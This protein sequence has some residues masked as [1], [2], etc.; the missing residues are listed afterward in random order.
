MSPGRPGG[1]RRGGRPDGAGGRRG[2]PRGQGGSGAGSGR[3]QPPGRQRHPG[4]GQGSGRQGGAGPGSGRQPGA[5]QGSGRQPASRRSGHQPGADRGSG[6]Q[7]A[8]RQ[9]GRPGADSTGAGQHVEGR[10]A[11]RELLRAGRRAVRQVLLADPGRSE[12]LADIADLAEQAGVAVRIVGREQIDAMALTDAPQGVIALAAP[13]PEHELA[14][15]LETGGGAA[16]FLV[17]LDGVT[18]PHNV[19]AVMRSALCAGATGMVLGRHRSGHLTPAAVKA[20]AGA[21]EHLPLATVTGIPAALATLAG[22]GVWTV[23]LD[24]GGAASLW[25][26]TVATEPVA[27]VLGAEGRGLSPLVRQRCEIVA[28]IP[29]TGPL[30]S[31]NVSAAAAL[32]C[33][34]IARRRA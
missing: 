2:T 10:Q 3:S 20:A 30:D 27:L 28:S 26:L 6:R 23:G 21:V 5:G 31:L 18:D 33:F 24:A 19:G 8:S 7:P 14:D 15:L 22:A 9:A 29:L 34:E 13:V 11:V 1:G 12:P 25:D 32:A 16:P 17:V 4:A